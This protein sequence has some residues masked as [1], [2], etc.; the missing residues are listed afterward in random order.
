MKAKAIVL[1]FFAIIIALAIIGTIYYF[2]AL[3]QVYISNTEITEIGD[4]NFDGFTIHAEVTLENPS[5]MNLKFQEVQYKVEF[6]GEIS[7]GRIEGST[8]PKKDSTNVRIN[9]RM[10]W[11]MA[12][13]TAKNLILNDATRAT[14]SGDIIIIE[15]PVIISQ[16]FEQ[17]IDLTEYIKAF[18][19]EEV[20]E[21]VEN[22]VETVKTG[23][24]K[25]KDGFNNLINDI[26]G[27]FN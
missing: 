8:I 22:V 11:I 26:G 1:I 9:Q 10:N 5:S 21:A 2:Y 3:N 17:Q 18:I 24:E 4:V 16:H 7:E 12:S 6:N 19:V 13:D 20:N 27:L 25:V 15:K 14:I 23:V